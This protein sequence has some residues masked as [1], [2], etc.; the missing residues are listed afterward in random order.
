MYGVCSGKRCLRLCRFVLRK[1]D[2]L[3]Q[4]RCCICHGYRGFFVKCAWLNAIG[5]SVNGAK[6]NVQVCALEQ[7]CDGANLGTMVGKGVEKV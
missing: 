1:T 5:N 2:S 6:G 7:V 4:K 3:C